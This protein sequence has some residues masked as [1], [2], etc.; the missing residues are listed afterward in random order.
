MVADTFEAA[1]RAAALVHVEYKSAAHA[2]D[3][4]ANVRPACA[5]AVAGAGRLAAELAGLPVAAVFNP[6]WEAAPARPSARAFGPSWPPL[7]T[8]ARSY[9]PCATCPS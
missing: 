8:P 1:R 5:G 9:S 3:L 7:P 2:T 6:D 4:A